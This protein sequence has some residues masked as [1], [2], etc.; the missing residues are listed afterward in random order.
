MHAA[1]RCTILGVME[2]V[3]DGGARVAEVVEA[4]RGDV[5]DGTTA[6]VRHLREM[7]EALRTRLEESEAD[8]AASVQAAVQR[9]TEEIAQLEAAVQALRVRL[10]EE[11]ARRVDQLAEAEQRF[12][13]E[14]EQL[15]ET[16]VA[17]RVRLEA[18][19]D[20]R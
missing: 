2:P 17:L 9:S 18:A 7:I 11:D 6:E 5:R 20:R 10:E 3:I 8:A 15:T 1:S 14:R 19:D 12:R 16:I 4:G 13:D